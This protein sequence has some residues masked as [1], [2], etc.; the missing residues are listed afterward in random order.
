MAKTKSSPKPSAPDPALVRRLSSFADA[1]YEEMDKLS[2]KAP[3]AAVSDLALGRINRAIRDMRA[4]LSAHD[5]YVAEIK[6]FVPAGTNPE[7][8]DAV[9]VLQEI[10]AGIARHEAALRAKRLPHF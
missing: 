4:L 2:K 5:P 3:S 10:R 6:E 7:V 1:L 8:R 9:L